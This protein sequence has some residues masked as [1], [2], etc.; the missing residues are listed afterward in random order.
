M[1]AIIAAVLPLLLQL[2]QETP[3]LVED[4]KTA[5]GLLTSSTPATTD[6]QAQIDAALDAAHT[7]LQAS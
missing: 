7:A 2:L 1:G 5:W 6:Q 3:E 4:V